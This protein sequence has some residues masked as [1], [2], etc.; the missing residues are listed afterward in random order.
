MLSNLGDFIYQK[1]QAKNWSQRKLADFSGFSYTVIQKIESGKARN[2]TLE[3]L[4]GIANALEVPIESLLRASE[5]INPEAY[6]E[7]SLKTIKTLIVQMEL[8]EIKEVHDYLHK[9]MWET[10]IK[11]ERQKV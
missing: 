4:R 9:T 1:R 7:S 8:N 2:L 6:S 10:L 3:T 11:K 5:G